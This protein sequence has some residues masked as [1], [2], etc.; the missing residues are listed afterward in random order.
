MRRLGSYD[1]QL[2]DSDGRIPCPPWLAV[3]LWEE[4]K[5]MNMDGF[6][7]SNLFEYTV[8]TKDCCNIMESIGK[9]NRLPLK[10]RNLTRQISPLYSVFSVLARTFFQARSS[11]APSAPLTLYSIHSLTHGAEPFLRSCQLCSHSR[12]SQRFMEAEGSLPRSQEPSTGP[13]P[14]PDR[15][16]PSHPFISL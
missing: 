11:R 12:T 15:S 2:Q 16:N 5:I 6:W 3:R 4:D 1:A 8:L 10:I 9:N 14:E 7:K 13:Y